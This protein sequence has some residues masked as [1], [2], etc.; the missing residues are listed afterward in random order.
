M[1]III[2]TFLRLC[3]C[4]S[5]KMSPNNFIYMIVVVAWFRAPLMEAFLMC[6]PPQSAL[7]MLSTEGCSF[8]SMVVCFFSLFVPIFT[9]RQNS[10]LFFLFA[11]AA[12]CTTA[13]CTAICDVYCGFFWI[14][15][16]NVRSKRHKCAIVMFRIKT[17]FRVYVLEIF[18]LVVGVKHLISVDSV[19]LFSLSPI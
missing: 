13:W 19:P 1:I 2:T 16:S 9:F 3:L 5:S 7:I 11:V 14:Q 15:V 4:V 6:H 10:L 12:L 18:A 17:I 8:T